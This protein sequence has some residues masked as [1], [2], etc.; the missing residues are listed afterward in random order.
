[1]N[2][3]EIIKDILNRNSDELVKQISKN[4][5]VDTS[6]IVDKVV[7]NIDTC[8]IEERVIEAV[9]ID[10]LTNNIDTSEIVDKAAENVDLNDLAR[11]MLEEMSYERLAAAI[12]KKLANKE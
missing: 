6:E 10:Q 4:I 3:E 1:M 7:D 11:L 8:D 9:D 2:I 5:S 12:I